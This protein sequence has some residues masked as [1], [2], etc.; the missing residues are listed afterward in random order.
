MDKKDLAVS[1]LQEAVLME[2]DSALPRI[3]LTSVLVDAGL[4]EDAKLVT[5]EIKRIDRH[6]SVMNWHGAQFKDANLKQRIRENLLRA[7]LSE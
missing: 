7:G 2:P 6:F 5:Q 3:Y 4:T 1:T